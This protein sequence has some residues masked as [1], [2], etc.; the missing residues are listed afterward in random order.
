[1]RV[2]MP[3]GSIPLRSR[4]R[5]HI[6][7]GQ[8]LS[9]SELFILNKFGPEEAAGRGFVTAIAKAVE[10]DVPVLV[11]VGKASLD[12]FHTFCGGQATSTAR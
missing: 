12:A 1:M 4:K 6:V 2:L 3:V 7:E 10:A 5:F 11:G 8:S 9:A